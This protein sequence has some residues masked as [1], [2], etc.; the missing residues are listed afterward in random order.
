LVDREIKREHREA[1]GVELGKRCI[2]LYKFSNQ[3]LV[4]FNLTL[5]VKEL[6]FKGGTWTQTFVCRAGGRCCFNNNKQQY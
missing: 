6:I 3:L 5:S 2:Y 4:T 1:V